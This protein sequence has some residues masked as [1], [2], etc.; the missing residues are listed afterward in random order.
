[1]RR[2]AVAALTLAAVL[3]TACGGQEAAQGL[4]TFTEPGTLSGEVASTKKGESAVLVKEGGAVFVNNAEI[5]RRFSGKPGKAETAGIFV[6]SGKAVVN[7]SNLTTDAAGAAGILVT[8]EGELEVADSA[9]AT[10]GEKSPGLTARGKGGVYAWDNIVGTTGSESPAI[11]VGGGES[12][13]TLDGGTF[14]ATGEQSPAISAAGKGWIHAATLTAGNAEALSLTE[15][16]AL[17]LYDC[18]LS[19]NM[20][21][22]GGNQKNAAVVFRRANESDGSAE[23]AQLLISG[24]TVLTQQGHL[25][26]ADGAAA[27]VVVKGST[28]AQDSAESD[29]FRASNGAKSSFIVYGEIMEGHIGTDADA[30]LKL[31]LRD[32]SKFTGDIVEEAGPGNAEAPGTTLYVDGTSIWVV[33]G[34][35]KLRALYAEGLVKDTEG[36]DVTIQGEDGTVFRKGDSRYKVTVT[37]E[38]R[39]SADFSGVPSAD[40][41]AAHAAER[42]ESLR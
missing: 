36:L 41:Y 14:T 25:F 11:L 21:A 30:S 32:I 26:Y 35:S 29:L 19:G 17:S 1:M 40:E 6:S 42:P 15:G 20:P 3:L 22:P 34:D 7:N 9:L 18:N 10:A 33:S 38:Y 4:K 8:G 23:A 12:S 2:K 13:M 27:T 39:T 31:Y 24:G 16:A 28:F 37:G 5:S